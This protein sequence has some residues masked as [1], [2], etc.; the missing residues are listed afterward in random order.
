LGI[1]APS[2]VSAY[3]SDG[4][5]QNFTKYETIKKSTLLTRGDFEEILPDPRPTSA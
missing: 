2:D 3:T 5:T 1:D 4:V